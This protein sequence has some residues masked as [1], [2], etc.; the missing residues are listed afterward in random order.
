M[1][2]KTAEQ[3]ESYFRKL[4]IEQKGH[5]GDITL[6]IVQQ[7]ELVEALKDAGRRGEAA[8]ARLISL[9]DDLEETLSEM[10]SD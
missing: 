6:T 1:D 7:D 3:L 5:L 2:I 4:Q 9:K 8:K 10:E